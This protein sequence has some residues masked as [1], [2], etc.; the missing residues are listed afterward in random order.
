MNEE[1]SA[2][3]PDAIREARIAELEER[4]VALEGKTTEDDPN[5][6]SM[7]NELEDLKK[8]G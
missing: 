7:R 3:M 4:I 5:L 2:E 8:Q 6:D 1:N